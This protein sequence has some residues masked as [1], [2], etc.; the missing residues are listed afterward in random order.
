L[1]VLHQLEAVLR[2]IA[3]RT[4]DGITG[5][6]QRFAHL[7]S[8]PSEFE[9]LL[10]DVEV[11]RRSLTELAFEQPRRLLVWIRQPGELV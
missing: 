4:D 11:E 2:I 7:A 5:D 3:L 10:R 1:N 8:F 9:S 6:I